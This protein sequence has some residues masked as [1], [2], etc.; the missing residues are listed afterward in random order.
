MI[1]SASRRTDIPAF[2]GEWFIR[3]VRAGWC[4]VP[5][6]YNPKQVST[7]SLTRADVDCFVF[8]TRYPATLVGHL[9]EVDDQGYPYY[10]LYTL[11]DYPAA[12][13]PGAPGLSRRIDMFRRVSDRIGAERVTWRYDP[14]L[15]TEATPASYHADRFGWIAEKLQGC[16]ARVI[17][18]FY[19]AYSRVENRMRRSLEDRFLP[20]EPSDELLPTL[21]NIAGDR[22]M[23]ITSCAE[24]DTGCTVAPGSCIDGG[25]IRQV[26]GVDVTGRKD[27]AQRKACNCVQSRDIGMYETCQFGCLYCYATHDPE[28]A[29]RNRQR[30]D[31]DAPSLL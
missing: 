15:I 7:V 25:L 31:P 2:F 26:F 13:E 4:S 3:R 24:T 27:P 16:T 23:K 30:H 12:L 1:V 9:P 19:D 8:W 5:N 10:F 6:P 20:I 17:V 11:V 28:R 14:I 18:S 22:G 29:R 21:A